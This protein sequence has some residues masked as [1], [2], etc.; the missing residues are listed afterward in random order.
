M[1]ENL[2]FEK[3]MEM[4]GKIVAQ[5]E[6]GDVPLEKSVELYAEG[7]RFSAE[8]KKQL[9]EARIKIIENGGNTESEEQNYE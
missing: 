2:S 9:Q 4:L 3:N 1:K 7:V 8:C 5:L 6:K